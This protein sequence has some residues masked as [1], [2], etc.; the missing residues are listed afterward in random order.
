MLLP[1]LALNSIVDK[2]GMRHIRL[3]TDSIAT[4]LIS[5]GLRNISGRL[6]GSSEEDSSGGGTFCSV[7]SGSATS[8]PPDALFVRGCLMGGS[9]WKTS[10]PTM[11]YGG[12]GN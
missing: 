10:S 7:I 8:P 3:N 1:K 11:K 5:G 4:Y 12:G 6:A 2:I 9:L